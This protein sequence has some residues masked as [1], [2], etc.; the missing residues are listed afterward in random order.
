MCCESRLI[1]VP[2]VWTTAFDRFADD[3]THVCARYGR[4]IHRTERDAVLE[5]KR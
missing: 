1:F 5:W 4:E 2:L 3:A